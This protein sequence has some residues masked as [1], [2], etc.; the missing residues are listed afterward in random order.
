[1]KA[2]SE[3]G[4]VDDLRT[5]R[6]VLANGGLSLM[7]EAVHLRVP[8]CA[9]PLKGQ[10][11]QELNA[12]WLAHLGYGRCASALDA[13]TIRAF[14]ADLPK[15]EEALQGYVPRDNSILFGCVD[16]LLRDIALDE[17]K[18]ERLEAEAPGKYWGPLL[19]EE[20]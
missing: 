13:A 5:A 10:Y 20:E 16:E 6:C 7:S 19:P 8:M 12:R 2:F 1:L 17:P 18:P 9:V 15:H 4:F 3:K 14:L 11:E